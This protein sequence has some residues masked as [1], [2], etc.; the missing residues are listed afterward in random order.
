MDEPHSYTQMYQNEEKKLSKTLFKHL[1]IFQSNLNAKNSK[2]QKKI[3]LT[4]LP[5]YE[6]FT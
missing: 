1:S 5:S 2:K 3:N 4:D 6:T